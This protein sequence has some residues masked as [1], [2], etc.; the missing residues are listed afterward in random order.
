MTALPL[1]PPS[2]DAV[3]VAAN[4]GD[5]AAFA[6]LV[7]RHR[8]ELH[9]H[10]ARMLRSPDRAED[11]VQ[12]TLL[13]AWRGRAA[14]RGGASYRTW[15][16]RIATNACL[17][18]IRRDR[19]RVADDHP[20]AGPAVI[21]CVAA[22]DAQPDAVVVAAEEV[23]RAFLAAIALLPGRQRAV[24]VL[25]DVLALSADETA[26]LL[27]ATVPAVNSALQRA[28]ATLR[29][30]RPSPECDEAPLVDL[31]AGTRVLLRG[32]VEAVRRADPDAVVALVRRDAAA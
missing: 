25:R 31:D 11:V 2:R 8:R 22:G 1:V 23:E 26:Q 4:A 12:E 27:G 5:D 20:D 15:L 30:A 14:F 21:E 16:Y 29:A 24:L 7:R 32:Y 9:G 17:D 10:C 6:T 28:R 13:R 19:P 3:V 18:E